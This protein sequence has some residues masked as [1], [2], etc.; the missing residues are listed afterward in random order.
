MR[1]AAARSAALEG[2]NLVWPRDFTVKRQV[3]PRAVTAAVAT[4]QR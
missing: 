3:R 4:A 2:L 1:R